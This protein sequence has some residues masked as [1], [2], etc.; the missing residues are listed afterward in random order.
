MFKQAGCKSACFFYGNAFS[1]WI[2]WQTLNSKA[3]IGH[4]SK[5][6]RSHQKHADTCPDLKTDKM[7]SILVT[8]HYKHS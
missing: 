6:I 2:I 4:A 5:N 1:T 7:P 3:V 8:R